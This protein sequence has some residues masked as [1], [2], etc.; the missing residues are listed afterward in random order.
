MG[1]Q[2]PVP[3]LILP[4]PNNVQDPK[5]NINNQA[6]I[7]WAKTVSPRMLAIDTLLQTGGAS[8]IKAPNDAFLMITGAPTI[9][10]EGGGATLNFPEPFPNAIVSFQI[11]SVEVPYIWS[12]AVGGAPNAVFL[13]AL[14][15]GGGAPSGIDVTFSYLAI[16]Y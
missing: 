9:R 16:G 7:R 14:E 5:Q 10:F 1:T 2:N 8:P 13:G 12:I 4:V 3:G 15:P 11:T 6:V